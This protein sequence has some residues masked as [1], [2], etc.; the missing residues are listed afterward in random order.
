VKVLRRATH[1]EEVK[2]KTDY[3]KTGK[4]SV[5]VF[6]SFRKYIKTD[7]LTLYS[8]LEYCVLASLYKTMNLAKAVQIKVKDLR[9]GVSL[10][11]AELAA[12]QAKEIACALKAGKDVML[13]A[14][15]EIA[16]A[17]PDVSP[18]EKAMQFLDRKRAF[19]LA[20]PFAYITG[21]QTGGLN[22]SGEADT[23]AVERGLK[24][25]FA[26]I[27]QP[28]LKALFQVDVEFKSQDFRTI[29][30]ALEALKAFELASDENLSREAKQEIL[31]RMFGLDPDEEKKALE[32]EAKEREEEGEEETL[33]PNPEVD[34][35]NNPGVKRAPVRRAE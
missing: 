13:D 32:K 6:V 33:D 19:V 20:L 12:N 27:I 15:D 22:A 11:D 30:S 34:P 29:T 9:A 10:N 26:S 4:S 8:A 17:S 23:M 18:T 3:E 1:D 2:I 28:V 31:A 35:I 7:M 16:T 25:Y 5:G 14:G 21:E 24:L